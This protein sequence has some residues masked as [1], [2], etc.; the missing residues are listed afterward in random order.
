L[1]QLLVK[2]DSSGEGGGLAC[3]CDLK[4]SWLVQCGE[5]LQAFDCLKF[6]RLCSC[7]MACVDAAEKWP[8]PQASCLH[9]AATLQRLCVLGGVQRSSFF[10]K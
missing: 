1:L 2:L 6:Q 9:D 7:M 10:G 8:V 4:G 3:R 5:A